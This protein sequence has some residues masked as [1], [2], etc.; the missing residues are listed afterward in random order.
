MVL[1]GVVS[2]LVHRTAAAAAAAAASIFGQ[3]G[4]EETETLP[5]PVN[6]GGQATWDQRQCYR[7][8][9]LYLFSTLRSPQIFKVGRGE[10]TACI[11]G[12]LVWMEGIL[13]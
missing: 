12:L 7:M 4:H 9:I 1:V 2:I 10:R 13:C 3:I 8:L 6:T 11:C 5:H